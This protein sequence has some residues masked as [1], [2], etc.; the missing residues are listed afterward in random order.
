MLTLQG[1]I[2]E[3]VYSNVVTAMQVEA[4]MYGMNGDILI[5]AQALVSVKY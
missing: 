4:Y 5:L 2:W 3:S 1:L